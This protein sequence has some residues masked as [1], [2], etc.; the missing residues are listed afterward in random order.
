MANR[1]GRIPALVLVTLGL[2]GLFPTLTLPASAGDGDPIYRWNLHD[3]GHLGPRWSIWTDRRRNKHY[4]SYGNGHLNLNVRHNKLGYWK[5]SAAV[6]ELPRTYGRFV[7]R[8]KSEAGPYTKINLNLWPASRQ[9]PPEINFLE[10]GDWWWRRQRGT[11]TLHYGTPKDHRMIH[12]Y[13][14]RDMTRWHDVGLVWRKDRISYVLDGHVTRIIKGRF[15]PDEPMKLH[16]SV[17]PTKLPN[18]EPRHTIAL[19]VAWVKVFK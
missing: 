2:V 14:V 19:K 5:G 15:V 13:Y 16:L 9:W 4:V 10:M 3:H 17:T 12:S 11:Q 7:V 1:M 6:L 8:C 18:Q